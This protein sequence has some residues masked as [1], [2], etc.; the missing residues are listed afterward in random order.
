MKTKLISLLSLVLVHFIG[1]TAVV[2]QAPTAEAQLRE[3]LRATMLQVRTLETEKAALQATQTQCADEK[4]A[5]AERV[6]AITKQANE[7]KTVAQQVDGLKD[8]IAKQEKEIARLREDLT[9]QQR[10]AAQARAQQADYAKKAGDVVV[11][12]E[13]LVTD[14]Q[15]KN[16]TLYQT[17]LEI[18]D[19][20]EKFS[21]GDA[22]K[23]REPF[24]GVAR[25]KLQNQVQEYQDKLA[26]GRVTLSD[27]DLAAFREQMVTPAPTAAKAEE[28]GKR[29]P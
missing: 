9:A 4:K 2:A 21:L 8:Q 26:S 20:Y 14:R 13:R 29:Q 12:L 15:T 6:E 7:Y 27:K 16:L 1:V 28:A 5:L 23:A 11:G 17:A 18:L 22:L 19:R 24:T 25:V 3:R 10:A